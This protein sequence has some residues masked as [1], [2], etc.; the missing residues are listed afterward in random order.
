MEINFNQNRRTTNKAVTIFAKI[1]TSFFL[2][3]FFL[4]GL[5]FSIL[6]LTLFFKAYSVSSWKQTP[7]NITYSKMLDKNDGYKIEIKYTYQYNGKTFQ[8]DKFT[9]GNTIIND[10]SEA[11][12]YIKKFKPGQNTCLVNPAAPDEAVLIAK[13]PW[14]MLPFLLIPFIF[15]C[16][17]LGGIYAT[18]KK[19]PLAEQQKEFGEEF[20]PSSE[21]D[22]TKKRDK[23]LIFLPLFFLAFLIM[24]LAVG[25]FMFLKPV[26]MI[27]QSKNWQKINCK[28]V[29]SRVK[30]HSGDKS[31]T[32]SVDILYTYKVNKKKY[33]SN[34]YDFFSGSSSSGY[35]AKKDIINRYPRGK[36]AKCYI[37]PDNPEEA[38][39]SR[40]YRTDMM[41]FAIIPLVFTLV[42]LIGVIASTIAIIRKKEKSKNRENG[43]YS[44]SLENNQS[45]Y[46]SPRET[47]PLKQQISPV[48]SIAGVAI[49]AILW[50][51][52]ISIFIYQ[53]Y[54]GFEKDRPD[55]FL[56]IFMIPFVLVGILTILALIYTIL[57][58]T[59][60][61]ISVEISPSELFPGS[62]ATIKWTI[63]GPVSRV[64]SLEIYLEGMEKALYKS[65]E[66]SASATNIFDR[67]KIFSTDY[68]L[69][70]EYGNAKFTIPATTMHSFKSPHNSIEWS[71]SV[72][73]NI[74]RWPDMLQ[75]FPIEI[76]PNP[77]VTISEEEL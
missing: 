53:I 2:L 43:D 55:W 8:S 40:E 39:I 20:T 76:H 7:C 45:D 6:M 34:R 12:G 65:G 66:N 29:H 56:T 74:K 17:G 33:K 77:V 62:Q 25:Y 4:F 30:S 18:W 59:N 41:L 5:G 63:K 23:A 75:R 47:A 24:G 70:M 61:K 16:V 42:G 31:T 51:G 28:I 69:A 15:M 44:K 1:S 13:T 72:I 22:I 27:N 3:I 26:I 35:Q 73:G 67:I 46:N 50:N 14:L 54:Q 64:T 9:R 58:S 21:Q 52:I 68:P 49:F 36:K 57:K 19:R 38:V 11:D 37:N 32:Y 60:P 71:V 10:Y 48:A